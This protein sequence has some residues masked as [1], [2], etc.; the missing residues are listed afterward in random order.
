M[1]GRKTI[2]RDKKSYFTTLFGITLGVAGGVAAILHSALT[3][4]HDKYDLVFADDFEGDTLNQ[5]HWRVEERV[6]G[7]ESVSKDLCADV[8]FADQ[9]RRTILQNDFNW[10]TNHNSYVADG[11]LWI[12]PTL[13]NETLLPTDYACVLPDQSREVF[14]ASALTCFYPVRRLLNSTFLQ[15][16][17]GCSSPHQTDCY[18]SAD[19]ENNQTLVIPPVQS[20]MIS[21]RDKVAI[22]YGRVVMRARMPTG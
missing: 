9:P 22:Q 1:K 16:G 19:V 7:G 14:L 12:V 2:S 15:L 10:F 21:T 4:G 6:G 5:S 11:N 18:I 20:A 17:S 3:V 8:N 13:T